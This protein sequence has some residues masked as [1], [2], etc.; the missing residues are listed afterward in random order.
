M[1]QAVGLQL[2]FLNRLPGLAPRAGMI[3]AFG[4]TRST[5]STT[6][7]GTGDEGKD[8]PFQRWVCASNGDKS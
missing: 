2:I 8:K 5:L 3:Q 7:T 1:R 4:L 6:F